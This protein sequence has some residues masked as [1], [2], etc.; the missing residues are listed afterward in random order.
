MKK[1]IFLL[2]VL[3]LC[4]ITIK[5]VS[6]VDAQSLIHEGDERQMCSVSSSSIDN[7]GK[8]YA[9]GGGNYGCSM[10]VVSGN[11]CNGTVTVLN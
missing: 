1:T 9:S 11:A 5:S 4:G 2:S 8:C 7:Y 3:F 6:I 10:L